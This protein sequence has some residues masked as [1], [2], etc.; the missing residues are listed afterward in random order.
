MTNPSYAAIAHGTSRSC[1]ARAQA[2]DYDEEQVKPLPLVI[3]SDCGDTPDK[4]L[5]FVLCRSLCEAC[6]PGEIESRTSP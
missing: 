3:V 4:E 2:V 6:R 1:L 5:T